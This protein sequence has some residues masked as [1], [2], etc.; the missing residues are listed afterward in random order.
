MSKYNQTY[1]TTGEFA[2]LCHTT[3]ETLFHY[4]EI[5][6]LK[7]AMIK[8]NGY[9]YYLSQQYFEFDFIKVLQESHM[10]LKEIKLF[11]DQ[12]NNESFI[13]ILKE[14]NQELEK[15]K[16]RIEN[17]QYRIQQTIAMTEYGLNTRHGAPFFK[18]CEEEHLLT[19]RLPHKPMNDQE[20]VS[21][22]SEHLE[23]CRE[24]HLCE[25]LPLGTIIKK[26][27]VCQKK[28]TEDLYYV[29]L[30]CFIDDERYHHKPKGLYAMILH[31]GYYDTIDES[32]EILLKYI[33]KHHYEVCSDAYEYEIHNYF[34]VEDP[35]QY[36]ISL[37]IRVQKEL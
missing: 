35:K 19:I 20:L 18:E 15:D 33:E 1:Y 26:E 11:K 8:D 5:N 14:K 2:K 32:F 7:P 22:I 28:Y 4:D 24:H 27:N 17:M 34:T 6:L 37:S 3:K 31:E 13:S 12:K 36:L 16:Q 29:V 30:N 21:C 9:R 23:Y 25:E 10:S